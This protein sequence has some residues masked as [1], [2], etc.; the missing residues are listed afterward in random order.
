MYCTKEIRA[1][2]ICYRAA[3]ALEG[4]NQ[5]NLPLDKLINQQEGILA[6][7][8]INGTYN[9]LEYI[10]TDR[11]ELDHCELRIIKI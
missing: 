8:V 3:T 6:N 7:E 11:Q 2:T 5:K 4:L 1:C 9:C 10:L